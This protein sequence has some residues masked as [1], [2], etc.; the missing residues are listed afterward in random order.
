[1]EFLNCIKQAY[2]V[3]QMVNSL[4]VMRETQVPSLGQEDPLEKRMATHSSILWTEKNYMDRRI[5]WTEKPGGLHSMVL[6]RVRYD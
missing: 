6:Q 2:L 4:P 1:M 5:L 3:A